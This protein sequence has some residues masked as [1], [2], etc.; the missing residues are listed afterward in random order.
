MPNATLYGEIKSEMT[1][2]ELTYRPAVD[3]VQLVVLMVLMPPHSG[4]PVIHQYIT[5]TSD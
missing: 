4:S 1:Q 3:L 5:A 2:C